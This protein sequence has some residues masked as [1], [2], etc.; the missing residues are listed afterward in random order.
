MK[1]KAKKVTLYGS[2]VAMILGSGSLSVNG[3]MELRERVTKAETHQTH[4]MEHYRA[5]ENKLDQ[6]NGKIDAL[7][8]KKF[9]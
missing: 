2:I 3:Y 6:I 7:I 4:I 9:Q 8:I 5:I 1:E